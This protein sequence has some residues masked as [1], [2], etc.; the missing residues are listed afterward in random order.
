MECLL[1]LQRRDFHP[2]SKSSSHS[3]GLEVW[4]EAFKGRASRGSLVQT[5]TL[6]RYDW[7]TRNI[8]SRELTCLLPAGTSELM[9]VLFPRWDMLVS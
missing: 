7:K 6:T 8:P 3:F 9:I 5:P 4:P 2:L 1:S